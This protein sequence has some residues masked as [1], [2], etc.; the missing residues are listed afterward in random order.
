MTGKRWKFDVLTAAAAIALIL[1]PLAAAADGGKTD[2]EPAAEHMIADMILL[3]PLGLAATVIGLGVF[4]VSLPF[5][6]PAG[7]H[8]EAARKLIAE[9]ASYTFNRPLG[10]ADP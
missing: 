7:N 8:K 10:Y 3:R 4:L 5:T 9:P 6:A 1:T 2:R